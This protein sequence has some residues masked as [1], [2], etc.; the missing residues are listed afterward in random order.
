[1]N[2][3]KNFV[4]LFSH[5][6]GVR[7]DNL[8]LFT[9]LAER[10]SSLGFVTVQFDYYE[11]RGEETITVPFSKQVPILQ[12]QIEKLKVQQPG[13]KIIIIAQSQGCLIPALCD[14]AGV[15]KVIGISPFLITDKE[16]IF[17]KYSA[18]KGGTT[19]FEGISRRLHS[20]GTVTIIPPEYWLERFSTN[21]YDL[22]NSLGLRVPF[23]IY[24]GLLDSVMSSIN[25]EGIKSAKLIN[26]QADHDF[27]GLEVRKR[28]FASLVTEIAG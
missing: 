3:P 6:F 23:V 22:Y 17:K 1:M 13:K 12:Q 14:L 4:I 10:L 28:L 9:F 16:A 27:N 20:D 25:L 5:G 19:N 11:I 8:G 15:V 21:Q 26:D 18:K 7:K 2:N 24:Y